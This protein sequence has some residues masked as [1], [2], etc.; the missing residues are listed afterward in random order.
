M[1]GNGGGGERSVVKGEWR[2]RTTRRLVGGSG[3]RNFNKTISLVKRHMVMVV[4]IKTAW[5]ETV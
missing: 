2:G 3:K 4:I 1:R 5:K